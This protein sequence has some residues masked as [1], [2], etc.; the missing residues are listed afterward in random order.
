MCF[1]LQCTEFVFSLNER[2]DSV[3]DVLLYP[4]LNLVSTLERLGCTMTLEIHV[5]C[6]ILQDFPSRWHHK[7]VE[8][9]RVKS[10]HTLVGRCA[11]RTLAIIAAA[12][13]LWQTH[14]PFPFIILSHRWDDVGGRGVGDRDHPSPYRACT[15]GPSPA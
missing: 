14:H 6:D 15:V 9:V 5:S 3:D 10:L 12:T 1:R 7:V 2:P 8:T 11:H 13:W 4:R